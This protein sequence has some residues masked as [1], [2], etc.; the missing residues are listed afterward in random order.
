MLKPLTSFSNP[1]IKLLRSLHDKKGRREAGLFLAEGLRVVSEAVDAGWTPH[2]LL[3]TA[4]AARHPL[5]RAAAEAC[6]DAG[7]EAV[8]VPRE[9]LAKVVG[10]DNPAGAAA[11][12]AIPDTGLARLDPRASFAWIAAEGLKDPGNLG[13]MLRTA[14]A[15]GAGGVILID[16]SCDPWS[17]EAVRASMGAVFTKAVARAD[18]PEFVAWARA[19][20]A[21]LAGAVLADDAVDYQ[22][23]RYAAPT[24]LVMGNEQSGLPPDYAAVCDARVMI[25]MAG[26]ADSLNVAVATAVLLYEV[27]NQRRRAS[28]QHPPSS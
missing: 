13:T 6:L 7:G 17:V 14:D 1:T 19:G 4:D 27:V 26:K 11:A 24:V 10:K 16:Q 28:A 8:D 25:P 18:W 15:T 21:M 3:L 12:F 5:G 2:V 23:P 9:L 20:G 22:A